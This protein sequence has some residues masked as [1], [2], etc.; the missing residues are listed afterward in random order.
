MIIVL[1]GTDLSGKTTLAD[2][3]TAQLYDRFVQRWRRGPLRPEQNPLNE[4]LVPL[5][6][7]PYKA[8]SDDNADVW[9]MDRWHLGELVYG[10]MFRGG[11][12]LSLAQAHY[13]ELVLDQL[14][15]VRVHVQV[16]T[17]TLSKRY[18]ERG[19]AMV[20]LAQA[21][22]L[23]THYTRA[24]L[25]F[26]HYINIYT[27]VDVPLNDAMIIARAYAEKRRMLSRDAHNISQRYLGSLTPNVLLL[28]DKQGSHV[29]SAQIDVR[30]DPLPWPFVP[31]NG[32]SGHWLF[33]TLLAANVNTYE[34]GLTNANEYTSEALNDL[35]NVLG[36]PTVVTLGN[37]ARKATKAAYIPITAHLPHPQYARRFQ[38]NKRQEYGQ[39]IKDIQTGVADSSEK[40]E[41]NVVL[42]DV[43]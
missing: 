34:I 28:G 18:T 38:Y 7:Y 31:Y 27:D 11:S 6:D 41:V 17:P 20:S 33:Q 24:M 10:P 30:N 23:K 3:I 12:R 15:A 8:V 13:I 43:R 2:N 32:T 19:D 14:A 9:I 21:L 5:A 22:T 36:K 4:Y 25:D 1:E 42:P 29:N 37:N 39:P 35:W 16:S 26:P 40:P